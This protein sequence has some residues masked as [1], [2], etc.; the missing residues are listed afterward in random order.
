[1]LGHDDEAAAGSLQ[2][3][4]QQGQHEPI[5]GVPVELLET[6]DSIALVKIEVTHVVAAGVTASGAAAGED[7]LLLPV[8]RF[9]DMAF[10]KLNG[11]VRDLRQR[12]N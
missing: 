4:G 5:G 2:I 11:Q 8:A 9:H 1:M 12:C 6:P 3:G 10:E 7:G